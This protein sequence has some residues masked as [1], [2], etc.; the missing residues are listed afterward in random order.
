ML[1]G[2][3]S[4]ISRQH[5]NILYAGNTS[6][7]RLTFGRVSPHST[8]E[9]HWSCTH[10]AATTFTIVVWVFTSKNILQGSNTCLAW[11]TTIVEF[12]HIANPA[13]L[14]TTRSLAYLC[15]IPFKICLA[16]SIP[17]SCALRFCI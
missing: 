2:Y 10:D 6:F 12:R 13:I 14:M 4:S 7:K 15:V 9:C 17:G 11:S 5:I 16:N 8:I 3:L 1:V